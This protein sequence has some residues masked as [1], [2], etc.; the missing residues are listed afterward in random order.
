MSDP[1][2]IGP[3]VTKLIQLFS[4]EPLL[5]FPDLDA[6]VLREAAA[7]VEKRSEKLKEVE[8]ALLVAQ[9]SLEEEQEALVRKA[10]R[11]HA[12]LRV[13]SENDAALSSK[14]DSIVLPRGPK[15]SAPASPVEGEPTPKKR[16]RP[17]KVAPSGDSLF[18]GEAEP[19]QTR[20]AIEAEQALS[21]H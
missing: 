4:E 21:Q 20:P 2:P 15:A 8:A 3:E 5:K 1:D 13:F 10:Q 16:G 11:A 6:A 19:A 18:S 17:R 7:R 14:V 9:G 12:Y